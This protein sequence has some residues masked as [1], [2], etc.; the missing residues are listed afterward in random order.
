MRFAVS[1]DGL[2]EALLKLRMLAAKG[3]DL[4]PLLDELGEDEVTRV[5]LRFESGTAPNGVWWDELTSRD[6]QPLMDTG[7]LYNS[8][9]AQVIGKHRLQVG[10]A[11]DYAHFH[12][13][14]TEHIPARPFLGV[15]D[16]LLASIKELTNAYFNI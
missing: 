1:T 9:E 5:M 4:S 3:E 13:F 2:D 14:G 6:G 12:Q 15:S 16:D 11:T 10:T 8:I 7:R